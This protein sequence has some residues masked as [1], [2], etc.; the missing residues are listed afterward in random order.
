MGGIATER[1]RRWRSRN[2]EHWPISCGKLATLSGLHKLKLDL[3]CQDDRQLLIRE[4][5]VQLR[6]SKARDTGQPEASPFDPISSA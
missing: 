5:V 6:G 2:E 3:R 1:S 4:L